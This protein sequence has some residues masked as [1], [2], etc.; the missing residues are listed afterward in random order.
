MA[1]IALLMP[2]RLSM[3]GEI[4]PGIDQG[5]PFAHAVLVDFDDADFGDAVGRRRRPGGFEVDEG[6]GSGR[7]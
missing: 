1:T 4:G 7:T 2:V 5:G 3:K 6:K